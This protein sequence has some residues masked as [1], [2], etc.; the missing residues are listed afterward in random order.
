MV[1]CS[2]QKRFLLP[3][4]SKCGASGRSRKK[5]SNFVGFLGTKSR[6][7]RLISREFLRQT[8][9]ESNR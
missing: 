9:Q 1:S 2:S 3:G 4:G 6:K 8:W 5:K 7:N